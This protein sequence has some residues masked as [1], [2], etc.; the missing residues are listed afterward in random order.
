MGKGELALLMLQ[1]R[2]VSGGNPIED[3]AKDPV[4]P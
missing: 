4:A 1:L 3:R 2:L